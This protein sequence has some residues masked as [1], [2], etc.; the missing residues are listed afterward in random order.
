VADGDVR[1]RRLRDAER[2]RRRRGGEK[3]QN[4]NGDEENQRRAQRAKEKGNA[5]P[6]SSEN[7]LVPHLYSLPSRVIANCLMAF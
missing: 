3:L 7:H 5:S 6:S 4:G 2:P 1:S